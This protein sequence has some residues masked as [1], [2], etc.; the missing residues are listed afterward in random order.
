MKSIV[1]NSFGG[2]EQL[3]VT[4]SPPITP[5]H[6]QVAIAGE[7]IGVGYMD[8]MAREGC[9]PLV[10][11][12]GFVPGAEVAGTIEA[13]GGGVES[14]ML[15]QRVFALTG[16]G[17][18]AETVLADI[19]NVFPLPDIVTALDAVAFGINALVAH[20][21][22]D[23]VD[24]GPGDR[25]LVRGAS[26][27]IGVMAVQLAA[28]RSCEVIAITSSTECGDRLK[29]LGAT[30]ALNRRSVRP[31]ELPESDVVVDTVAGDD[32]GSFINLLGLNGRYVFCGGVGGSPPANFGSYLLSTFHRSPTLYALSLNSIGMHDLMAATSDLFGQAARGEIVGVIDDVLPL[33][34]AADAH[35]KLESGSAFGKLILTTSGKYG[36]QPAMKHCPG[37][38]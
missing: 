6:G 10:Q 3:L 20:F 33:E 12:P 34:S 29:K 25:V 31:E 4:D 14:R 18:Y 30:R 35:R 37:D 23:R 9:Y 17:G 13:V 26:G 19:N 21:S 1:V 11:T 8:V 7:A 2:P 27:G 5:G 38:D 15:G 24:A 22:L 16:T 36:H 28:N 32:V